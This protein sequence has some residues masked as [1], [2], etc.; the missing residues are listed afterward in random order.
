[1]SR[2]TATEKPA[3]TTKKGAADPRT[4]F[5]VYGFADAARRHVMSMMSGFVQGRYGIPVLRASLVGQENSRHLSARLNDLSTMQAFYSNGLILPL[6]DLPFTPLFVLALFLIHPVIGYIGVVG[7]LILIAVTVVT[8]LSSRRPSAYA[9]SFDYDAQQFAEELERRR[10]S[11]LSLGMLDPLLAQWNSRKMRASQMATGSTGFS[12]FLSSHAR[13]FRLMLQVLALGVGAWLVLRQEM[14]AGAIIAGSILMGRALAPI[15]QTLMAWRQIV[16]TRQAWTSLKK[17]VNSP[18]AQQETVT[19]LPRPS[20]EFSA[21]N[22][23]VI[24]P[25]AEEALLPKFNLILTGGTLV[26]IL[27]P[28]GSG[29]TTLLQTLTGVWPAMSGVARLGGRDLHRWSGMDR[30]QYIGYV[31]QD[32][33]LLPGT[34]AENIC[35]F[36]G[37]DTDA[38]IATARKAGFHDM[39]VRMPDGYDTRIGHGGLYLSR[40]QK[41]AISLMRALYGDPVLLCLDEPSAN[42]DVAIFEC[43]KRCLAMVKADGNIILLSTHDQRLAA[44]ADQV[45][46]LDRGSL[47]MITGEEFQAKVSTLHSV[48]LKKS[49]AQT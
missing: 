3:V 35:R 20:A 15:D 5:V 39:I 34:I 32:I 26:V 2:F 14:S 11:V 13:G 45:M 6:F 28:S 46:I 30:G 16:R 31:P 22:L 41:Q 19:P 7:A 25:G 12:N 47:R 9:K 49:G 10:S 23:Q 37:Q 42:M 27:G 44:L 38:I 40:G 1:M 24:T 29:K 18:E 36:S 8:E 4:S 43:L 48:P 21:E 17:V 33:D